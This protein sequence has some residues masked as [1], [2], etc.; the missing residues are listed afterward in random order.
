VL[1][2][3]VLLMLTSKPPL[4][5]KQ[6]TREV[7]RKFTQRAKPVNFPSRQSFPVLFDGKVGYR[8][9]VG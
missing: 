2:K 4:Q 7:V 1:L 9:G 6:P 3:V 5:A 8:N